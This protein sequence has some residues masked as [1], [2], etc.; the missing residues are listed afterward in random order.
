[1][2]IQAI[3]IVTENVHHP[4]LHLNKSNY[5]NLI[6]Q[7]SAEPQNVSGSVALAQMPN[8]SFKSRHYNY[9]KDDFD[10][11]DN[12]EGPQPPQIEIEKYHKSLAVQKHIDEENY[13]AAIQGKIELARICRKQGNERDA[14]MLENSIRDLYKDLP[15]YQRDQAKM[16][17]GEY[18][19]D[20]AKYIDFDI[21][22]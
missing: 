10:A 19:Y 15:K 2:K 6:N 9:G 18:N 14:Y 20:M 11:Y 12:Y 17:I 3:N 13:L 7:S 4:N 22:K 8:V 21:N 1:M 16:I 5:T